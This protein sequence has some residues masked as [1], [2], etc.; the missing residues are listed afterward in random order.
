MLLPYLEGEQREAGGLGLLKTNR[1]QL[2]P[3][4]TQVSQGL[5][6]E[7]LPHAVPHPLPAEAW[8]LALTPEVSFPSCLGE[9]SEQGACV[10]CGDSADLR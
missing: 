3:S 6:C 8:G 7:S 5:W 10:G 4:P 1:S 9:V 2:L